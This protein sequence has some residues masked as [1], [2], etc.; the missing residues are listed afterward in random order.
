MSRCIVGRSWFG[1]DVLRVGFV[2]LMALQS[3]VA[4][5]S[6]HALLELLVHLLLQKLL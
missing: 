6:S 4:A 5:A 1:A 3:A 2:V